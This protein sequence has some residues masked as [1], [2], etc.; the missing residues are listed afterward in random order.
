MNSE[1][2][3]LDDL[4]LEPLVWVTPRQ[5]LWYVYA[6][7]L[8]VYRAQTS[9]LADIISKRLRDAMMKGL[10]EEILSLTRVECKHCAA[11]NTPKKVMTKLGLKVY[12]MTDM[13]WQSCTADHIWMA[14]IRDTEERRNRQ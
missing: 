14:L 8:V 13:G 12:H 9:K 5:G 1:F 7:K 3:I 6:G 10:K 2:L 4:S 11:L